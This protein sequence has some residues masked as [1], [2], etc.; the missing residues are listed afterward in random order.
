MTRN[1]SLI[2]AAFILLLPSFYPVHATSY[3]AGDDPFEGIEDARDIENDLIEGDFGDNYDDARTQNHWYVY[4][5]VEGSW[6]ECEITR[7]DGGSFIEFYDGDEFVFSM[8]YCSVG[9]GA[10]FRIENG[11]NICFRGSLGT[12]AMEVKQWEM[13]QDLIDEIEAGGFS[14]ESDYI[15]FFGFNGDDMADDFYLGPRFGAYVTVD[16]S[17]DTPDCD[18]I[19][20]VIEAVF[21]GAE[22]GSRKV[23]L[24]SESRIIANRIPDALILFVVNGCDG[25]EYLLRCQKQSTY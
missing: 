11:L 5:M 6:F 16:F 20:G 9:D 1:I 25:G 15:E 7:G 13:D 10:R 2:L 17:Y 24:I 23:D 8:D 22:T 18:F 4:P 19:A 21:S 12:Y 3:L 14:V